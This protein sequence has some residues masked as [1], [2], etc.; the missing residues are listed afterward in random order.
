[1][2]RKD[3]RLSII[4]SRATP[5]GN[6]MTQGVRRFLM[7]RPDLHVEF[8]P[9]TPVVSFEEQVRIIRQLHSDGLLVMTTTFRDDVGRFKRVL[10]IPTVVADRFLNPVAVDAI[11]SPD[12][13][14]IGR[15]AA[16]FLIQ[17][18]CKQFFF[19][20]PRNNRVGEQRYKAYVD[21]LAARGFG[22]PVPVLQQPNGP[23]PNDFFK[24]FAGVFTIN[25]E[26]AWRFVTHLR[27]QGIS[28]PDQASVLGGDNDPVLCETCRPA[29]SSMDS[30]YMQIGYQA[31]RLLCDILD[32][33]FVREGHRFHVPSGGAIERES[34]G[35]VKCEEP[36]LARALAMIQQKG[37]YGIEV[38]QIVETTGVNR[39]KL[40]RFFQTHFGHSPREEIRRRQLEHGCRLLK[41]TDLNVQE[42]ARAC[43]MNHMHFSVF[44]KSAMGNTPLRWRK[45]SR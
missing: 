34:T 38:T 31:T 23:L 26:W 43:G 6:A 40:E 15:E 41:E 27:Q 45:A 20:I 9:P 22:P 16:I 13:E 19:A 8:P 3:H 17:K 1:M 42:V 11:V 39:R 35:L 24:G 7:T 32:G 33:K 28:I 29:I 14:A 21:T 30:N 25:D 36:A 18:G 5:S 44:F 2:R 12:H 10:K 4:L 37:R